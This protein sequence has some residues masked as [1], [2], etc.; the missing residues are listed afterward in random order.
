[1]YEEIKDLKIDAHE[2]PIL[3]LSMSKCGYFIASGSKDKS[4]KVTLLIVSSTFVYVEYMC[5]WL[6]FRFGWCWLCVVWLILLWSCVW[7][8]S[9]PQ[10]DR[11]WESESLL[12]AHIC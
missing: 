10:S 2:M 9:L 7:V 4:I 8:G 3:A 1:M 12:R 5:V 6:M 11:A